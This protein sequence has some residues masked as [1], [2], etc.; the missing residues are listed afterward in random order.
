[1]RI[2]VTRLRFL[3]DIVLSTP[4]LDTL[5]ERFPEAR[6]EYLA[7]APHAEVL[8]GHPSVDQLHVLPASPAFGDLL[9]AV[10]ALRRGPRIDWAIDLF[11]NPRSAVIVALSGALNRVGSA[12]GVRSRVYQHR[13]RR[14][15]GNRSAIRHHLDKLV[16]LLGELPPERPTSLGVDPKRIGQG[17]WS[18][19]EG[20]TLVHPG[21]TWPEKAWLQ[22]R[23]P[24][25]IRA[26]DPGRF[27]KIAV[28]SPPGDRAVGERV[29][30]TAGVA[31]VPEL[32]IPELSSLLTTARCYV[33]NDG[34]VLHM[35]VAHG[36]PTVGLFGPTEP[37]IW[38]P[39]ER[40]GPFKVVQR[41]DP[42]AA[43]GES[44]LGSITVDEV[45]VA[46]DAVMEARS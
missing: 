41:C 37:D 16:P 25:L 32:S 2:L 44:Q 30:A 26:L 5:R 12:R 7:L 34:G 31:L 13:R 33:G 4:L 3:G 24:A 38:F 21:S 40:F 19:F 27:G 23:W 10:R 46:L 9:A 18:G 43:P 29:A 22:E 15:E 17:T 28:I 35:A 20:F 36:V 6:I 11:S 1:M 8:R 14:P 45:C 42:D 39:Y